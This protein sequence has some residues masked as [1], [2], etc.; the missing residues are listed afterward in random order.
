MVYLFTFI[1]DTGLNMRFKL[2]LFNIKKIKSL[3][4]EDFEIL[5]H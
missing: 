4:M 5:I 3:F 2:I 1:L